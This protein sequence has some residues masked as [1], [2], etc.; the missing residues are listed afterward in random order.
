MDRP[1]NVEPNRTSTPLG[2]P[3][4]WYA[5]ILIALTQAI[6]MVDRQILA[7]LAPR[8]KAD[9]AIGDAEMGLLYGTVFALFYALF[10]LPLGRLADGWVRKK[11]LAWSI[12]GWSVM[13]ALGGFANS[14]P[15][16]AIS[17]LGVGIGEASVQ[18]AGF[19]LL[20]DMFPKEKRGTV[21][22]V[23]AAS[24]ALGLGGALWLGGAVAD[25]WDGA[26][27]AG[28]APLGIKGWQAA[29]IAAALP[30][31]IVA[32]LLFRLAEP[33]RGA[34]DGIAQPRDPHAFRESWNTLASIL[35][36]FSWFNLA[37]HRA[38]PA[39][40]A[41]N[42]GGLVAIALGA[43]LLTRWTNAIRPPAMTALAIG[44]IQLGGNALQ[45]IITGFGL[46]VMLCW[47]QSLKLRD[48]PAYALI[49][50]SPALLATF[51]IASLQSVINYGGMA[52]SASFIVK[53]FDQSIADVGLMFGM[54]VA[55]LGVIGPLIAGPLSDAVNRR[56]PG[57]RLYVTL[58]SLGL[59]SILVFPTFHA[60]SITHFY[61]W[62]V[63]YS[64]VLTMWLPP[65][66]ATFLDLVLPRMRGM[67]MSFYILAM[68]IIGLGTG[69]YLVGLMSDA[70]GD[71][72]ASIVNLYWISPLLL[73]L[74]VYVIRRLPRDEATMVERARAAGEAI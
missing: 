67:V 42:L 12:L 1:R 23:I 10:S 58:G 14:F 24:I 27:P 4:A 61:L 35:P 32:V 39:M 66:Y 31:L 22:A 37:R 40:W 52:W 73:L 70:S 15:I 5:L 29:F 50:K 54:L 16:L 72:G 26:F 55:G 48:A 45:W 65:V 41:A 20:S 36:V 74:C 7:I 9:L 57:G 25:G 28:S 2:G 18:P 49:A 64:F 47:L 63:L 69:P 6:S 3:A 53:R 43:H 68:T 19:S 60:D 62:F 38:S 8:I 46:Y 34:A 56:V 17:R 51:A 33:V 71:L 59:S 11:L 21:T 30:G 44:P 13:T